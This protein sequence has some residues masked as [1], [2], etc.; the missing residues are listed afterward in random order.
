[1][2]IKLLSLITFLSVLSNSSH[3]QTTADTLF[4]TIGKAIEMKLQQ[5]LPAGIKDTALYQILLQDLFENRA[6]QL[7][8]T[9]VLRDSTLVPQ[10]LFDSLEKH[11]SLRLK[12]VA[13]MIPDLLARGTPR[14]LTTASTLLFGEA[15]LHLDFPHSDTTSFWLARELAARA[16][17]LG[18]TSAGVIVDKATRF[19][20]S[21]HGHMLNSDSLKR[22][23]DAEEHTPSDQLMWLSLYQAALTEARRTHKNI[24]IDFTGYMVTNARAMESTIFRNSDVVALLSRFV[25]V[26][27]YTDNGT[28]DNDANSKMEETRF[29]TIALPF[30][31]IISPED[32]P[33]AT[34][35]G[36]TRDVKEFKNFLT[37][38][39]KYRSKW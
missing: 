37:L 20:V 10:A 32:K 11:E 17:S 1:M 24:F 5:P 33:V 16:L 29:G 6:K 7:A 12:Q 26:R 22:V 13:A 15:G 19:Y 23:W 39:P 2:T 38:A 34:F 36:F 30:Y 18:D 8:A 14:E 28:P 3:G 21:K 9:V 35:P 31:A 27:L 4:N 25:L